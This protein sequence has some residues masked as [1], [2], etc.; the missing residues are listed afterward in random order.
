MQIAEVWSANRL[1]W[2]ALVLGCCD[3]FRKARGLSNED[4]KSERT[5]NAKRR[6]TKGSR[7]RQACVQSP[8][9]W[10]SEALVDR[11]AQHP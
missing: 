4:P 11:P 8:A 1:S 3:A 9:Q 10:P 5:L 6:E 2:Q 7:G